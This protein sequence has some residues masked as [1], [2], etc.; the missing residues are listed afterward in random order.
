NADPDLRADSI[1]LIALAGP[2]PHE[3]LLKQLID[4]HEPDQVQ[5]ASVRAVGKLKGDD[6]GKFSLSRWR[7][8]TPDGRAEGR[9]CPAVDA[10]IS[11]SPAACHERRPVHP[12]S[13]ASATRSKRERARESRQA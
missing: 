4:P 5:A 11:S 6:I 7:A 10:R 9:R 2:Q 13:R 12:R 1:G 3:A 8:L